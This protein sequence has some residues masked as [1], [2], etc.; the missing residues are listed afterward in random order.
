MPY[1]KYFQFGSVERE[2]RVVLSIKIISHLITGDLG[3]EIREADLPE[4]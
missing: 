3:R 1:H 4:L 2:S